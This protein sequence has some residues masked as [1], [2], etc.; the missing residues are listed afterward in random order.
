MKHLLFI[1]AIALFSFGSQAQSWEAKM[2]DAQFQNRVNNYA[3][4][5]S[6]VKKTQGIFTDNEF[7]QVLDRCITKDG[8]FRLELSEDYSTIT[9]YYLDWIDQWTINWLFTEASPTLDP[10]LR[11]H[12]KV[13]FEF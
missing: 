1:T 5:T 7:N 8:I 12:Q 9:V 13:E 6:E 4:Y 11:I 3:A 2:E 10:K